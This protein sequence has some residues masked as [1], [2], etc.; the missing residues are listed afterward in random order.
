MSVISQNSK[1]KKGKFSHLPNSLTKKHLQTQNFAITKGSEHS[2]GQ[3]WVC[4][5]QI[6]NPF[7][8]M[9]QKCSLH[10]QMFLSHVK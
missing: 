8:K 5:S 2:E 9:N 1:S 10:M 6:S 3:S 4:I 7:S